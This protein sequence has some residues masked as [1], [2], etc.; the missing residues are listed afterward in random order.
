[1]VNTIGEKELKTDWPVVSGTDSDSKHI[2][3]KINLVP[4][5]GSNVPRRKKVGL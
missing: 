1:M 4:L 5:N 2:G 3:R